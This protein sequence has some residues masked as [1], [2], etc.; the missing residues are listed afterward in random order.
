MNGDLDGFLQPPKGFAT[1][2]IHVG[3]EPEQWNSMA[4][5]PPLSLSTTFKQ[6]A[7]GKH[8]VSKVLSKFIIPPTQHTLFK[9]TK[10]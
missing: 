9:M 1:R 6:H 10:F 2:A 8:N 4:V 3:Q 5:V 7:P